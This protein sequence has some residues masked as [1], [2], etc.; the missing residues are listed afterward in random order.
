MDLPRQ[1]P[2]NP[3]WRIGLFGFAF[4]GMFLLLGKINWMFFVLGIPITVIGLLLAVR[5]LIFPKFLKIEQDALWIPRG[6]LHTQRINIPYANI[7]NGWET[8]HG[9]ATATLHLQ[10]K[11]RKF[12]I[13]SMMLPDA[14]SY[15]A[16]RDFV[17]SRFI[18]KEEPKPPV[19]PG[20]YCFKCSYEGNG[21]I[22]D[23]NGG[24]LWRF[25]AAQVFCL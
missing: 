20:K 11:G 22:Y 3:Q 19:E 12:E 21:E 16:V 2:Y 24:I 13:P 10:V 5:R 23:S 4:G 15:A 8:V 7:E 9:S 14:A 18:L 17:K 1:F 25:T 6:F